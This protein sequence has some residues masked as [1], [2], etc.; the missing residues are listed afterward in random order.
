MPK[1]TFQ[2]ADANVGILLRVLGRTSTYFYVAVRMPTYKKQHSPVL[3]T[4]PTR[5]TVLRGN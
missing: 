2:S 4:A 5:P 1:Y 3:A